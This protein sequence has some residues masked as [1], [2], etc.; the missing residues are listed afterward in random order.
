MTDTEKKIAYTKAYNLIT[1]ARIIA[2]KMQMDDAS[3]AN[4]CL[5]QASTLLTKIFVDE[6]N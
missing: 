3:D 2:E 6:E 5:L 1:A 4:E